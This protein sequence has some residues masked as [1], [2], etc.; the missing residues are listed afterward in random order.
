MHDYLLV[1]FSIYI[2]LFKTNFSYSTSIWHLSWKWCHQNLGRILKLKWRD[3]WLVNNNW[4][5]VNINMWSCFNKVL[6]CERQTQMLQQH[7][8]QWCRVE[9]CVVIN[10][11][12]QP[13]CSNSAMT[14]F[15][16]NTQGDD[17]PGNMTLPDIFL[18]LSNTPPN[19]VV[20]VS[21]T[22]GCQFMLLLRY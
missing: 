13:T 15:C 12:H 5:Y 22:C 4:W 17:L 3:C 16:D 14:I 7:S 20:P 19:V 1:L 21:C 10:H 9:M 2:S 18:T 11:M 6:K 8:A